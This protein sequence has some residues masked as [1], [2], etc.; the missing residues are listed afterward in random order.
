MASSA[1]MFLKRYRPLTHK[2]NIII[3]IVLVF[4]QYSCV[5][6][7]AHAEEPSLSPE[8]SQRFSRNLGE[9]SATGDD[10]IVAGS[11]MNRGGKMVMTNSTNLTALEGMEMRN[12]QG[13]GRVRP[14]HQSSVWDAAFSRDDGCC[15]SPGLADVSF[16]DRTLSFCWIS[17]FDGECCTL[18][19]GTLDVVQRRGADARSDGSELSAEDD[20]QG[21]PEVQQITQK[22]LEVLPE[23]EKVN[24]ALAKDG[25]KV[26]ASNQ[27]AKRVG[28]LLDDDSDTFMRNDCKDNKWVVLELSQVSKVSS[29]EIG[30]YELYSSRVRTFSVYGMQSHPRTLA[31]E[32]SSSVDSNGWYFMGKFEASKA[33]GVQSF[34]IEHPRWARYL[35]IRFLTHYG[36]ES[37]CAINEVSVY[38]TSA[39]EELEA[40]LAEDEL[41]FD[42][43]EKDEKQGKSQNVAPDEPLIVGTGEGNNLSTGRE[44]LIESARGREEVLNMT[45]DRVVSDKFRKNESQHQ[46]FGNAN[47]SVV[48][49]NEFSNAADHHSRNIS[50]MMC[51]DVR[52]LNGSPLDSTSNISGASSIVTSELDYMPVPKPKQGGSVYEILVQELRATK[53][54]QKMTS[55]SL[56]NIHKNLDIVA[57]EI[58]SLRV[59]AGV[60]DHILMQ[61]QLGAMEE[62]LEIISRMA[63]TQSKAAISLLAA[64]MGSV[65]LQ[66]DV[67]RSHKSVLVF[68]AKSLVT[69]NVIAGS[70]LILKGISIPL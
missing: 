14:Y 24:F 65:M 21:K 7:Q 27:G 33:K 22:V 20:E 19:K 62:K 9:G 57:E 45:D 2:T 44:D 47:L 26:L 38:G 18:S 11:T 61:N 54:Q 52:L 69:L 64:I 13:G 8:D 48:M 3:F 67:F 32:S 29:L 15:V 68:L 46:I 1:S 50:L 39:A 10:G 49:A 56:E 53:A 28:A 43:L 42:S 58:A 34:V 4:A 31:M 17:S 16:I 5:A 35:L 60:D 12:G 6:V 66:L 25:A 41:V 23:A 30:Q 40:Q 59:A 55:K 37:V 63:T 51:P 36:T 70:V